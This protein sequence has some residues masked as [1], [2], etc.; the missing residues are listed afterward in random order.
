VR[1]SADS[2]VLDASVDGLHLGD[3][4]L[5]SPLSNASP[6]AAQI[7]A[8]AASIAPGMREAARL[9]E[10]APFEKEVAR[11]V[12]RD[13]C[14]RAAFAAEGKVKIALVGAGGAVLAAFPAAQSGVL[15]PACARRGDPILLRAGTEGDAGA[16]KVHAAVFVAP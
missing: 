9:D 6:T 3:A 4:A 5:D 2:G 12:E 16:A 7:A 1:G 13:V 8:S 15:G 10:N 14:V 11:G